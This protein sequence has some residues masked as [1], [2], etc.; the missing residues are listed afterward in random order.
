MR[1]SAAS[2][3]RERDGNLSD[4]HVEQVCLQV[5]FAAKFP[6]PGAEP[7][8]EVG[9]PAESAQATVIV[10]ERAAEKE[11]GNSRQ[12][13]N[14]KIAVQSRH[15]TRLDATLEAISHHQV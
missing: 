14:A 4:A 10:V 2:V 9:G 5:H 1:R 11:P 3:V 6:A 8:P 15:R 12:H 13:G 7:H